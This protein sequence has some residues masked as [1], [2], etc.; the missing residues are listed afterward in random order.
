MTQSGIRIDNI[1][2]DTSASRILLGIRNNRTL[3][4]SITISFGIVWSFIGAPMIMSVLGSILFNAIII[5]A[6]QSALSLIVG[7][8]AFVTNMM[9]WIFILAYPL[10]YVAENIVGTSGTIEIDETLSST[11]EDI[12][13][14]SMVR[15]KRMQA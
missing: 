11:P 12:A 5:Q 9:L 6:G 7:T 15:T 2:G 13:L 1:T 3:G 8:S 14:S 4:I 10:C